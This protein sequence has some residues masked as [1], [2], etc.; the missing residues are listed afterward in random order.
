MPK[1]LEGVRVMEFGHVAAGPFAGM[2]LA[3]LGADVVKI[4]PPGGD[5]MRRW[6]PFVE[7]VDGTEFSLNFASVNRGKRSICAD[8]KDPTDRAR[9][10]ELVTSADVIVENYRPGVLERLGFGF[11]RVSGGHSRGVVYCSVSGY[12]QRGPYRDRGA[13]DVV[14]QAEA[15]LMS[16]TGESDGPPVKCGV[17][18]GDFV[19]GLYASVSVLAALETRRLESRSVYVDCP[20]LSSLLAISALQTS[21]YWGT[22]D[23]PV[24]L[25]SAHPRNA[26]YQAFRAQDRPFAI[27]AGTDELWHVV[28]Q[29]VDRE[30]LLADHRFTTQRDR[31]AHQHE[32]AAELQ[33]EFVARPAEHW[34]K[35]LRDRGVPSGPVNGYADILDDPHV[36]AL[37]LVGSMLLPDDTETPTVRFPAELSG[38]DLTSARSA[39]LL[40]GGAD[41][42]IAEWLN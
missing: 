41:E 42:V 27:A 35:I 34:L 33:R 8:L 20:M 7:L 4:E 39:P 40:G 9:I 16:V 36:R 24:P 30:D 10:A 29:I 5:H 14:I 25:G 1:P 38:V 17:P 19:A 6:P 15:G 22:G 12:G 31:A 32:L 37:Q 3:D 21:Q 11:D 13:F 2:V 18:V 23:P 28:A 26:P